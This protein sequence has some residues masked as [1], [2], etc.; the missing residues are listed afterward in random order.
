MVWNDQNRTDSLRLEAAY[1][2]FISKFRENLDSARTFG[3]KMLDFANKKKDSSWAATTTR[4][5]GNTYAVQADFENA[6]SWFLQ[7]SELSKNLEDKKNYATTIGNIGTVYYELGNYSQAINYQLKALKMAE[8]LNDSTGISRITNNLGNIYLDQRNH[9]KALEFYLKSLAL[10]KMLNATNSLPHIFNNVGLAYSKL[11]Q[12]EDALEFHLESARIAEE[13]GD[14]TSQIRAYTNIGTEHNFLGHGEQAIE[15]LNKAVTLTSQST[16]KEEITSTFL[17][18]GQTLLAQDKFGPALEDCKKSLQMAQEIG[19]LL[20]QEESCHCL[21]LAYEGLGNTSLALEYMKRRDILK[22]SIFNKRKTEEITRS[23]MQYDFEKQQ[24]ADSLAFISRQS[25]QQVAFE[26]DLRRQQNKFNITLFSGVGLLLFGLILWRFRQKSMKLKKEQEVVQRLKQVDQLKDQFLA[27]TSHELR[28][29]LNGIIGLTESLKDGAAGEMS[30]EALDNLEMIANS[31]KRLTHLVNDILDFSKLKNHDIKLILGPVDIHAITDVVLKISRPLAQDKGLQLKNDVPED[32][33]LVSADENRVQQILYNLVGNA[34]KFSHKG[35]ISVSAKEKEGYLQIS[36]TDKGIG[37][38]EDKFDSIFESFEQG[39]GS[40]SRQFGGTGLGLAVTKQLVELHK[41]EIKVQ[42]ELGKGSIFSFTLPLS[43]KKRSKSLKK[44][45]TTPELIGERKN[46][47]LKTEVIPANGTV[48]GKDHHVLVIDD[49]PINRK[50]LQNYLQLAGYKITETT[51]GEEALRLLDENMDFDIVLCDVMMPGLSGYEVCESIRAT[52][53]ASELPVILLTAKNRVSD[54]VVGFN[55]GAN[56]YLTKP[57]AK[58]ELLSRIKTHLNL[59]GIH[60]AT[61]RFVPTAFIKSVGREEI[62]EVELGDHAEKEVTVLFSDIR[63][64][65][66]LAESMTPR[67]NFKFVNSYVGKMGPVIQK[68][69]GF[70]NQYLGDGIMALFPECPADA[71][72]AAIEMKN[73]LRHYNEK[74]LKENKGEIEIGIGIHTGKLIMGIIGDIHRNDTA[75]ISDTVNTASRMEGITKYFGAEIIISGDSLKT[76][77]NRD[78][79]GLR[80][81]GKVR[82]LG[83]DNPIDVYEC[84]DGDSNPNIELKIKTLKSFEKGLSHFM[85][86]EFPK[87]SA[88]FDRVLAVNP[89]DEVA[90]YFMN[91]SAEYTISGVPE[92]WGFANVMGEK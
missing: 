75:I 85:A 6:L 79:F 68:N 72:R 81:L 28:T 42:S 10:K 48:S 5:I 87:A 31:G 38:P 3:H 67:Q 64:Y 56:D 50:V 84:F 51:S 69:N 37:I 80:Y 70:V 22:D 52:Y 65:T 11:K 45:E 63:G 90:K 91:K 73:E 89:K 82:V 57:I 14:K 12:H 86:E 17:S 26:R 49:E 23:A 66:H 40:T 61:S 39:D 92:N 1:H 8:Q 19:V 25:Q 53:T 62:T 24:L 59:Y 30:N 78:E 16:A 2:L 41:G 4:L 13:L 71:L 20:E 21:S 77:E 88:A 83:K 35:N 55:A 60:K 15:Y 46:D 76:I 54:L 43:V 18:R 32:V 27:N 29:P 7:S 44:E 47:T 34:I 74:R 36:V 9:Q 33:P 58:N